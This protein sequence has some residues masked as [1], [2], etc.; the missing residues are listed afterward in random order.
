VS[1]VWDLLDEIN[2]FGARGP[3][4]VERIAWTRPE[5][6]AR[7]WLAERCRERGLEVSLDEAGNVWALPPGAEAAVI[8]G[9]HLDTVPH[10]GRFD[11]AL[12][13]A[14]ALAAL[15]EGEESGAGGAGLVCFTDEE[16]VRF[17]LGMTGSRAVAGLLDDDEV[18][19]A[20]DRDGAALAEVLRQEGYDPARVTAASA[21]RR[22]MSA[23][24]EL[25]VEQGRRLERA[26]VALGVV[27]SIAGLAHVKVEVRGETN[28]AGTT[29]P[30]DRRDA[31]VPVA[32]LVLA[33][34]RTMA[35]GEDLVA[36]VGDVS[37][38]G[39]A[40]N[41]IPGRAACVLDV[42]SPR[43]E[44]LERALATIIAAGRD[45]AE[46]NGCSLEA[47]EVKRFAPVA[48]DGRAVEALTDAAAT[49]GGE[50]VLLTSMAGHDA[51]NL[52]RAEVPC[53][54]LFVRSRGGVS[55]SPEEWSSREDCEAGARALR[56]AA[57]A[58]ARRV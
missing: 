10:A 30:E 8:M 14:A 19:R 56:R 32:S 24:L 9:S 12:G 45:A 25:H 52:A 46:A 41:V 27:G 5:I 43:A 17:G 3:R 57:A 54:M 20:V 42:R 50:P 1:G 6:E 55:H 26:G 36:T 58:L 53:G 16:G 23:Y 34:Q 13:I 35:A 28:H 11:G 29:A 40:P 18:A 47:S 15:P 49:E 4:E 44:R 7:A 33:A 39:G 22:Q 21:R 51:M 37:V 38:P 2:R 31:L 48:M